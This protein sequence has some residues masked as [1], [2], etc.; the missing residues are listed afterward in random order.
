MALRSASRVFDCDACGDGMGAYNRLRFA[1]WLSVCLL[2]AGCA[3]TQ[4]NYNT[5]EISDTIDSILT[6]QVLSNLGR[7][8]ANPYAIPSMTT[9]SSGT[10]TT[11]NSVSPSFSDPLT[12]TV[13]TTTSVAKVLV[14]A[15]TSTTSIV[16][17][18]TGK[19]LTIGA[20][21]QWMQ[22]WVTNPIIENHILRR[23]RA[24]YRFATIPEMTRDQLICEYAIVTLSGPGG[25]YSIPCD[26]LAHVSRRTRMINADPDF[27]T[28]PGCVICEPLGGGPGRLVV[29]EKLTNGWL[30]SASSDPTAEYLLGIYGG[31]RLYLGTSDVEAFYD[32]ILFVQEAT[33]EQSAASSSSSVGAGNGKKPGRQ[34]PAKPTIVPDTNGRPTQVEPPKNFR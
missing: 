32:F 6:K 17:T 27:I 22:N 14:G 10:V 24:L 29:N 3:S 31:N 20:T 4:L 16:G 26:G 9:L 2:C 5:L 8:V 23:L 28:R 18:T 33:V 1:A 25:K 21:D 30:R 15:T 19:G 13:A 34:N 12:D 7:F 11:T